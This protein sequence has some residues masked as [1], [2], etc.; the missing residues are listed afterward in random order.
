MVRIT[1][2][3]PGEAPL[4]VRNAWVGLVLPLRRGETGPRRILTAGVVT[5]PRSRLGFLVAALLRRFEPV[6]GFVIDAAASLEILA[7][8]DASAAEWWRDNAPSTVAPGK[9]LLFHAEVCEIVAEPSTP[10][11][12]ARDDDLD[13]GGPFVKDLS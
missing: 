8:H 5:G 9:A 3:P 13:P 2:T 11:G 7:E 4:E 1:K 12:G 6:V 10:A